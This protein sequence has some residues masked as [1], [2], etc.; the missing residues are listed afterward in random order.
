MA[1][2]FS[3]LRINRII[4]HQVFQRNDNRELISPKFSI[5]FTNLDQGGFSTLQDRIINAL[6]DESHSIEMHINDSSPN[7][8]F[9]ICSRLIDAKN[10]DF[11]ELSKSIPNKLAQAQTSR[12]IPGGIVVLFDGLI[13]PNNKHYLGIIKAEIHSGFNIIENEN[14]LLLNFLSEL[15][16]TPQQK[17]YKIAMFIEDNHTDQLPKIPDNFLVF[18]YD[19][20][21]TRSETQQAA[22]YFYDSFLGCS[23]SPSDKKLTSDFYHFTKDHIE[24]M[25][26]SE[27]IKLDLNTSLYSYLKVSQS[28]VINVV[29]YA[30]Q[31]LEQE[32]RD[33]YSNFM[34][35]KGFPDRAI[36][37]DITYI[38]YKL[39][40]RNLKFTS[41]VKISAPSDQFEDL[42]NIAGSDNGRTLVSIKGNISKEF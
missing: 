26:V 28:N 1:F 12:K 5:D 40:R 33:S 30:E 39:R 2:N 35:E 23:F 19:H 36:T 41:D 27:E 21:M 22:Q 11:K 29:E 10:E 25:D 18:V 14:L 20:N 31:Y 32:Q 6:G 17:L 16:L 15:L 24:N 37:K 8:T 4:V 38:K 42:V 7:S 34:Y 3:N 13:G 9:D